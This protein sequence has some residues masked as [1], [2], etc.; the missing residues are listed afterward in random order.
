MN[1]AFLPH[2]YHLV[3]KHLQLCMTC[4]ASDTGQTQMITNLISSATFMDAPHPLPLPP[5]PSPP[6]S[7]VVR[8]SDSILQ[9]WL[10]PKSPT[11]LYQMH[12][13]IEECPHPATCITSVSPAVNRY[14]DPSH[15]NP[16]DQPPCTPSLIITTFQDLT[17]GVTIWLPGVMST[18]L[19]LS[20]PNQDIPC[21]PYQT[22]PTQAVP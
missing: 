11:V 17:S 8:S 9:P 20:K 18:L 22:I 10:Q 15:W 19:A 4:L 5:I 1:D 14:Q 6:L 12:L 3:S 7:S 13:N 16:N 2:H 21:V